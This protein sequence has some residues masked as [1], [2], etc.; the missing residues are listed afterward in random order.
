MIFHEAK[1]PGA[2]LI[3]PQPVVDERGFFARTWSRQEF[4]ERGLDTTLV[5][6]SVSFNKRRGT[7]RGMHYQMAPYEETK[8]VRCTRGA[9]VDVIL[10]MRPD[11][12][13]FTQWQAFELTSENR[14]ELHVPKGVA[15]GF[16]T[17]CDECEVFYQISTV[18][19]PAASQ[20][21]CWNDPAFAIEWP[22][23]PCVVS[24]R[25]AAF[26]PWKAS[27]MAGGRT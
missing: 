7:L 15:H 2:Y 23:A 11:S 26:A 24:A 19:S 20:G 12:P 3:E 4:A 17:R 1:I 25:D 8:L 18:Y 5:Q 6:C 13:T 9:I 10:D 27:S 16:L 21:V 22:E 14:Y